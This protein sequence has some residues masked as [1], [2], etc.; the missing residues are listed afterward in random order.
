[1]T[2]TKKTFFVQ[3]SH[4]FTGQAAGMLLGF[5]TFPILTRLLSVEQYG[6]LALVTNT[7]AIAV[8]FSKMGM[9]D[10]IVRFY[11]EYS[12]DTEKRQIFSSTIF[13][14]GL[15][16][17]LCTVFFYLL[18]LPLVYGVL[19]IKREFQLCFSVMATYLLVR[20]LSI[21]FLNMLRVDGKTIIFNLL[22]FA[23]QVVSIVVGLVLL[24]V[25]IGKLY[26][27][28]IGT[29]V[30]EYLL[31]AVLLYWFFQKYS[32]SFSRVSIRLTRQ[33]IIF[34]FPLLFTELAYMLLTYADRYMILYFHGEQELGIYSVGY[35]LAMYVA[36][37]IVFSISYAVMPLY[38]KIYMQKG[39][40]ETEEFLSDCLHYLLI[41]II[42]VCVGYAAVDKELFVLLASD[43]FAG[44]A[45]FSPV[46]LVATIILGMNSVLNAGLYL[47]KKSL[48][49]LMIIMVG[50]VLNVVCNFLLLPK[51][52]VMG[53]A[54]STL[55]ACIVTSILTVILSFRYLAVR[56]KF[57]IVFHL[58]LSVVMYYIVS[59][60]RIDNLYITLLAKILLGIAFV[61]PGVIYREKELYEKSMRLF[62][63]GNK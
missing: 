32:V 31:C 12:V 1:M 10:A 44:A 54:V 45:S 28:F 18:S 37:I 42:P 21:I 36:N 58:L 33:L 52:H 19:H 40:K 41:L 62:F 61:L 25:V 6:I 43:K 51:L 2:V 50:V 57:R 38:V 24:L 47:H 60:I 20:P 7:V 53:A 30:A 48:T 14:S 3:F 13:I 23:G 63:P 35:N 56:L 9:S 29:A 4:F 26:G 22:T 59:S 39:R 16:L 8:V 46:I 15:A 17:S 27:Y 11:E 34:G 55:I 49:I 5:I